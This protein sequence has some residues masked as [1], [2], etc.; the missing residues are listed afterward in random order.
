MAETILSPST[1]LFE[2]DGSQI[3]QQPFTVGAAL[4]GPTAIG[5]VE[6]PTLVTSYSDFKSKFGTIFSTGSATEEYFT[7]LAAY[8]YFN[9]GGDTLLVTRVASGSYTPATASIPA[10]TGSINSFV[11]ETLSQG[12]LLNSDPGAGQV[13]GS[14]LP[15][16]SVNNLRWEIT[17]TN[18]SSSGLFSLAIRSGGDNENNKSVLETWNNLSLDPNETTFIEYV[19]GNQTTQ[20]VVDENGDYQIQILGSYPNNSRYVRVKSTTLAPNYNTASVSDKNSMPKIGSGSLQGSFGG[21]TG[22]L[23]GALGIAPLNLFENIPTTDAVTD[24]L[25]IQGLRN[26]SYNIAINLLKNKDWYIFDAVFIPGLTLQNAPSQVSSLI[27]LAKERGDTI[28]V[29]DLTATGSNT[30]TAVNIV[31]GIDSNYAATYYPWVTVKSNE[32]GKIR[33]VPP[34]TVIPGVFAY[35]DK[36]AASWFAPAG[37]NR[38]SLST[39]LATESRLSK[40]QRDTLYNSRINPIATLPGSGVVIYGQK[41]LQLNASALDRINVRR[42]M[43]TLKRYIGQIANT[44]LFEQNTAAT[45]AKFVNQIT[46]YL[47]SVQ[48]R[49]G[50]Y[51]ATVIMDETNNTPDVIDRN[52]LVGAIQIQPAKAAEYILLTFNIE[53]TGATFGA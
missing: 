7:S 12:T 38:G 42:L 1:Y 53:P 35:N 41:T 27:N 45:R 36:V 52:M 34:S 19:I 23:F 39:V 6:R 13:T 9:Q 49:Q 48:Q 29:I 17:A 21:A 31:A 37:M 24:L 33:R 46:P 16:G 40:T 51:S 15:S 2:N 43:I 44:F 20:P 25:N 50:L 5:P 10:F 11:L 8:T 47:E 30:T 3:Q 28:A 26:T 14:I 4:I 32:T 22:P 18:P